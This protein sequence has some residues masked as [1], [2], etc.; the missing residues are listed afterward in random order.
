M[1]VASQNLEILAPC[2]DVI[3]S[4]LGQKSQICI[5]YTTGGKDFL[6]VLLDVSKLVF[7]DV[8]IVEISAAQL[9]PPLPPALLKMELFVTLVNDF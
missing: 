7:I 3:I 1:K 9:R 4:K 6:S 8:S 2:C 5:S